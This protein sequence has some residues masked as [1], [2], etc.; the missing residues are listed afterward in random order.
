MIVL[1]FLGALAVLGQLVL[2]EPAPV[3]VALSV[4]G[5]VLIL[6]GLRLSFVGLS[7]AIAYLALSCVPLILN[8]VT[9]GYAA[10]YMYIEAYLIFT[11]LVLYGILTRWPTTQELLVRWVSRA[12][13]VVSVAIILADRLRVGPRWMYRDDNRFRIKG[14]FKDP[15]VLGPYLVLPVIYFLE[16][17]KGWRRLW[18]VPPLVLLLLTYSRGAFVAI[19]LAIAVLIVGRRLAGMKGSLRALLAVVALGA[20]LF[21]VGQITGVAE[22]V[23]QKLEIRARYQSYDAR[24]FDILR[25]SV[26]SG[27]DNPLGLG[28][29]EF[30]SEFGLS[31]HDLFLGKWVDAGLVPALMI[32]GVLLLAIIRSFRATRRYDDRLSFVLFATL[33]GQALTS[34]TIY[35]H[36]WRHL[37][38]LVVIAL[39]RWRTL[40]EETPAVEPVR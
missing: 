16:Y 38:M 31:A 1:A 22:P 2:V 5:L 10:S 11:A 20:A 28:A 39:A 19:A 3:D 12:A 35:S 23:S 15:N 33:C 24:R 13:A 6:L 37:W 9:T 4:L 14:A 29:G 7:V 36:H 26:D 40:Q 17:E 34:T 30:R 32:T 18:A 27:L 25:Q 8:H 21:M